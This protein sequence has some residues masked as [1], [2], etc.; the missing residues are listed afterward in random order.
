VNKMSGKRKE[1]RGEGTGG[2]GR[3]ERSEREKYREFLYV[4]LAVLLSP[5]GG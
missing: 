4:V 2:G 1:M 3:R 5:S